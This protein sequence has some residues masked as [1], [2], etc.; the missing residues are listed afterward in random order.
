[1]INCIY[2]T[3]QMNLLT[4]VWNYQLSVDW[5]NKSIT[6]YMIWLFVDGCL[7]Y[8]EFTIQGIKSLSMLCYNHTVL[9]STSAQVCL[10][11]RYLPPQLIWNKATL[12]ATEIQENAAV[13]ILEQKRFYGEFWVWLFNSRRP[14]KP[15]EREEPENPELWRSFPS[16]RKNPERPSKLMT[17]IYNELQSINLTEHL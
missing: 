3:D 14:G 11:F 4:L 2:Y 10:F 13:I 5:K 16:H 15:S 7:W 12:Y 9:N 6:I 1:M 8:A 17:W